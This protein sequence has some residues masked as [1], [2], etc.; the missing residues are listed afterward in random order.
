VPE[1]NAMP[2]KLSADVIRLIDGRNFARMT[3]LVAV[4]T[5]SGGHEMTAFLSGR[6][7]QVIFQARH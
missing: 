3:K 5:K 1:E 7:L 4:G 2:A 6:L